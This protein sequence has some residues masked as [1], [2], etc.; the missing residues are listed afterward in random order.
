MN[1][2]AVTVKKKINKIEQM[3]NTLTYESYRT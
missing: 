2:D 3:K 1:I